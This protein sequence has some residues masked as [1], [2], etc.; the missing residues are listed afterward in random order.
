MAT[1]DKDD[2]KAIRNIVKDETVP[3]F[4][5]LDNKFT[6]L[7]NFLDKDWSKLKRRVDRIENKLDITPPE[8]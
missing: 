2:L 3:R 1:L 7:F 4:R 8:F 5:K 6:K